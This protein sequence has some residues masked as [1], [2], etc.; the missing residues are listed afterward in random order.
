[1]KT[2]TES[3]R[4]AYLATELSKLDNETIARI[5][6]SV[7]QS[8]EESAIL[9]GIAERLSDRLELLATVKKEDHPEFKF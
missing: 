2:F 7:L 9:R 1:M 3:T 4:P 8:R 6:L 5:F